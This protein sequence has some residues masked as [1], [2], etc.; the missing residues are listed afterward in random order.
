M[1]R[2]KGKTFFALVLRA[3]E[4][5]DGLV[6]MKRLVGFGEP[7]GD[8]GW[9]M[10]GAIWDRFPEMRK[11]FWQVFPIKIRPAGLSR[12]AAMD[13]DRIF[14][15]EAT[16]ADFFSTPQDLYGN[17]NEMHTHADECGDEHISACVD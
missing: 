15:P 9:R 3:M 5:E 7:S 1:L 14:G 16:N 6:L 4:P 11:E 2:P 13:A 8:A 12:T 10:A 17:E